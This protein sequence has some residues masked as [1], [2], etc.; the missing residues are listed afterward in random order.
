MSDIDEASPMITDTELVRRLAIALGEVDRVAKLKRQNKARRSAADEAAAG[1]RIEL[2]QRIVD[3]RFTAWQRLGISDEAPDPTDR[4]APGKGSVYFDRGRDRWIAEVTVNGKRSR[5]LHK[6]EA[7]AQTWLSTASE[8]LAD[9]ETASAE[10]W[11]VEA[12]LTNCLKLWTVELSAT[13]LAMH[14]SAAEKWWIPAL[15]TR[16][17]DAVKPADISGVI[18]K[19]VAVPLASNSI[20]INT[21]TMNKAMKQAL[22]D[23]H[24]T[25]N[26]VPLAK[27]PKVENVRDSKYLTPGEARRVLEIAAADEFHG[28]ALALSLWLGLRRGEVLGLSWESI[29][30]AARTVSIEAM[31]VRTP[32]GT[33]L[34]SHVKGGRSKARTVPVPTGVADILE[35]RRVRQ[36]ESRLAAGEAWTGGVPG[37]AGLVFTDG[38]G[39]PIKPDNFGRAV[40][41][42]TKK[43]GEEV[44]PHALRHSAATLL[45]SSGVPMKTAQVILGHS[46]ITM[47][48]DIYTHVMGDDLRAAADVMD[49][50]FGTDL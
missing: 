3:G 44:N 37:T 43:A 8:R 32:D 19:M 45:A 1:L 39:E 10:T 16:R 42:L 49:Q 4:R 9:G 48:A 17:L 31:L 7:E 20:R 14:R 23:E 46:S 26:V 33:E 36:I 18:A 22:I 24:V 15:G 34:K 50:M 13:T 25:R 27:R 2:G 47:T 40:K 12:W 38:L 29:D 6:T 35:R 30:L 5:K 41:R 28:D 21:T 11:T